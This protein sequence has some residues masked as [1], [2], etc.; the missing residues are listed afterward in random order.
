MWLG[1]RGL[2]LKEVGDRNVTQTGDVFQKLPALATSPKPQVNVGLLI[3]KFRAQNTRM[4]Q[5]SRL[6][7]S[8][9]SS[10]HTCALL[11][12]DHGSSALSLRVCAHPLL[13][14]LIVALAYPATL[15]TDCGMC[16]K[17]TEK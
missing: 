6:I 4:Q 17:I 9:R 2:W 12:R 11:Q 10:V 1:D 15:P 5:C 7:R 8:L 13:L 3:A 14:L 16:R